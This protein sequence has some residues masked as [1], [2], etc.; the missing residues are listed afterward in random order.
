LEQTSLVINS[1][2]RLLKSSQ[3]LGWTDL[4]AA[5]TDELPH[6][7]VRGA[8]PSVWIVT[9]ASPND[10]QRVSSE[11][12]YDKVLPEFAVSVT[13]SGETVY[14]ELACPLRARHL[15]LRQSVIDEVA[16][17]I[18]ND[19]RERR[20]ISSSFGLD[21]HFLYRLIAAIRASLDEPPVGNQLKVGYLTQA[22]AAYLLTKY[23][24][25]GAPLLVPVHALNSRQFAELGDYI[26]DNLSSDMNI[27]ELG[28]IVGL[29][30]AQFIQRFKAT[31]SMTPHQF[32]TLRRINRA[33]KLLASQRTDCALIALTCGFAGQSH[34][35]TTFKR[36]VGVT[37]GEYRRMIV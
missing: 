15:Y 31:T 22:L 30:R 34:F 8:V 19:S 37:P 6:E 16:D 13:R 12:K 11:R 26:N 17:E 3:G 14:D 29:G 21:D 10:I 4:F 32:V 27:N 36:I 25:V 2:V 1:K 28:R 33:R 9:A 35:T 23:S 7:G 18:F 24:I 20:F 5:V